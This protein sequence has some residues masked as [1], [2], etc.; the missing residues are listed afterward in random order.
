MGISLFRATGFVPTS[1]V[2][3]HVR[4]ARIAASVSAAG[5]ALAVLTGCGTETKDSEGRRNTSIDA[6]TLARDTQA[7]F[8]ESDALRI[9]GEATFTDE[10]TSMTLGVDAC[11]AP[12]NKAMEARITV[13]GKPIEVV[14]VDGDPYVKASAA[15][16]RFLFDGNFGPDTEGDDAPD[17][18]AVDE[19]IRLAGDRYIGLGG[20]LGDFGL[21]DADA[22]ETPDAGGLFGDDPEADGSGKSTEQRLLDL[23][24]LGKLLGD[25]AGSVVKGDP[26]EYKGKTVI[27]LT[28]TDKESGDIVTVYV[29]EAGDPIPVRVTAETPGTDDRAD[30]DIETG[31]DSCDPKAPPADQLVDQGEFLAAVMKVIGLDDLDWDDDADASAA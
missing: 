15:T 13:D 7:A 8:D 30:V 29:P 11:A 25:D 16:W 9:K 18:A 5:L 24:D 14:V 2:G 19:L 6:Q 26:V 12:G 4:P 23:A 1:S 17:P 27:P 10:G 28:A 31:G 3:D 22:G 20:L 21:D